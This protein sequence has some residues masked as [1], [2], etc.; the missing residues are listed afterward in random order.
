[1]LCNSQE[2]LNDLEAEALGNPQSRAGRARAIASWKPPLYRGRSGV[3]RHGFRVG[4]V[5]LRKSL[6]RD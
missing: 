6:L 3:G 2:I 1:M 4:F 5:C